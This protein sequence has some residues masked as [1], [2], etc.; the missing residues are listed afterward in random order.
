MVDWSC[1]VMNVFDVF[2]LYIMRIFID[3]VFFEN[4]LGMMMGCLLICFFLFFWNGFF[5]LYDWM[6]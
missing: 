6:I 3:V 4:S 5:G 1:C 2:V